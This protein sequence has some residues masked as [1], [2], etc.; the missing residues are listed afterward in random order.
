MDYIKVINEQIEELQKRQKKLEGKP[1]AIDEYLKIAKT[2][3]ELAVM[4]SQ[5]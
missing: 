3:S 2:I 1:V 4:A 5:M